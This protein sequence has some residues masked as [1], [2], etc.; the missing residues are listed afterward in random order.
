M[1][2][3]IGLAFGTLALLLLL[4]AGYVVSHMVSQ[5]IEAD[6]SAA[7]L[8][9]A[10]LVA[11]SFDREIAERQRDLQALA[12]L[13]GEQ[14]ALAPSTD[15]AGHSRLLQDFSKRY[16]LQ[17]M[18]L[19]D[20][21]GRVRI[22]TDPQIQG[23]DVSAQGWFAKGLAG[24]YVHEVYVS[25]AA[26][27][28]DMAEPVRSAGG[29]TA[30][31]LATQLREPW[32]DSLRERLQLV[33]P[34][35]QYGQLEVFVT[36]SD[37][38]LMTSHNSR[39]AAP[40][41]TQGPAAGSCNLGAAG[42]SMSYLSCAVQS[43]GYKDFAGLG[44]KV[45]IRLPESVAFSS[46]ENLEGRIVWI[47]ILAALFFGAVGWLVADRIS[48]PI[49]AMAKAADRI[50]SGERELELP[51]A[52]KD[53]TAQLARSLSSLL[54][55]L[56]QDEAALLRTNQLLEA[57]VAE[58]TL[59][60]EK[61]V[62][63]LQDANTDLDRFASMV[64]HDLLAPVRAMR[65]FSEL[66]IMDFAE[67]LPPEAQRLLK[68]IDQA[69]LDMSNLV[70][71]L[72]ALSKLGQKPLQK[73][74]ADMTAIAQQTVQANLPAWSGKSIRIDPLPHALCDP[75]MVRIVFDNLIG[76][77]VKYSQREADPQIVVSSETGNGMHTYWVTDN[78]A[79]FDPQYAHR[80]FQIFQRLH[81]AR[82]YPGTGVGLAIVAKI[83][84]RHGG[85][86]WAE[87]EPGEGATFYFSL[88]VLPTDAAVAAAEPAA[89]PPSA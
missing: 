21:N 14:Q 29:V 73:E 61:A 89:I 16:G 55:K 26:P 64:S 57:R 63:N 53:E 4:I 67:T 65:A 50:A 78:G 12:A 13:L 58:R 30:G 51:L 18:V 80:L 6:I 2:A 62:T 32:V 82:D 70:N 81:S 38:R 37:G 68:R 11:F 46:A 79:G 71:A 23:R 43:G 42:G 1:R 24:S 36:T 17:H 39:G 60:L 28:L 45:T 35:D 72:H 3:K 77:A 74:L 10:R 25:N 49:T 9:A 40:D 47:G 69:G 75:S 85:R 31:V 34:P 48:E 52:G 86:V 33:A 41:A 54:A 83:V 66:L 59:E 7:M 5:R 8:R 88:P 15:S 19:T 76:N 20:S 22:S 84:A 56:R 27:Y 44:W 87:S